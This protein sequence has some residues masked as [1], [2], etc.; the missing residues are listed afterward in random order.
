MVFLTVS[1][2]GRCSGPERDDTL[3]G[4]GVLVVSTLGGVVVLKEW[5]YNSFYFG[6]DVV[7]LKDVIVNRFYFGRVW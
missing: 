3:V 1:T 6:Q 2:L 7:V 4:C 5:I